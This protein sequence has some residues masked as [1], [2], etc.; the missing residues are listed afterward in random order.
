MQIEKCI[1]KGLDFWT[2]E[3]KKAG[4][5][6]KLRFFNDVITGTQPPNGYGDAV[7]MDV[8]L[9]GKKGDV[10]HTDHQDGDTFAR[11]FIHIKE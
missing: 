4:V 5:F 6:E 9:N 11:I 10:Y 8:I 7:L 2:E 1:W 3:I